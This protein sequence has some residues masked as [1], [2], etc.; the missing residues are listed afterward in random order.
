MKLKKIIMI[1]KYYFIVISILIIIINSVPLTTIPAKPPTTSKQPIKSSQNIYAKPIKN[2]YNGQYKIAALKNRPSTI[3]INYPDITWLDNIITPQK[4]YMPKPRTQDIYILNNKL[5]N[6]NKPVASPED[7]D[8]D[9][10]SNKKPLLLE[11]RKLP[12]KHGSQIE[13]KKPIIKNKNVSRQNTDVTESTS[14]ELG[15]HFSAF[16]KKSIFL[17]LKRKLVLTAD[18]IYFDSMFIEALTEVMIQTML[19]FNLELQNIPNKDFD[20]FRMQIQYLSGQ[21]NKYNNISIYKNINQMVALIEYINQFLKENNTLFFSQLMIKKLDES[22]KTAKSCSYLIRNQNII[23][24]STSAP[25]QVLSFFQSNIDTTNTLA[26]FS[27]HYRDMHAIYDTHG[28]MDQIMRKWKSFKLSNLNNTTINRQ[29]A[30][31]ITFLLLFENSIIATAIIL[32]K[33]SSLYQTS[34]PVPVVINIT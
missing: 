10:T 30:A 14:S 20:N 5:S 12:I 31:F 27:D 29:Y 15:N 18:E 17:L 16:V 1:K 8:L 34:K 21:I 3:E 6:K 9:V 4:K 7:I 24:A 32:D 25:E 13:T 22:L 11:N 26:D 23:L 28:N 33:T 19:N 2:N